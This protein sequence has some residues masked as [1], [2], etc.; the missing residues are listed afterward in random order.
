MEKKKFTVLVREVH[1]SHRDIEA[2]SAEEAKA[3]VA[4]GEGDETY[5]EYSHTLDQDF[6]QVEEA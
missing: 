1:I 4:D 3:L 2:T 5:L 6:W